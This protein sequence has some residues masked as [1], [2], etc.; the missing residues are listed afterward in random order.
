M[1]FARYRAILGPKR[2]D[3]AR[4]RAPCEALSPVRIESMIR[5]FYLLSRVIIDY[6]V[7]LYSV[8]LSIVKCFS[9]AATVTTP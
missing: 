2:G 4:Y 7:L 5:C 6:S 8:V 3:I 1:D 9:I